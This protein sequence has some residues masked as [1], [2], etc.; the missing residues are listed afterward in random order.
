MII[1]GRIEV[2]ARFDLCDDRSIKHMLLAELGDI[3]L[4]N[5][6]LF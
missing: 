6:R 3:G 1:L 4:G 5:L 2:A